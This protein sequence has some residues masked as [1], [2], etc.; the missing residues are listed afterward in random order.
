MP[1]TR[2]EIPV[3][4][5]NE[6]IRFLEARLAKEIGEPDRTIRPRRTVSDALSCEDLAQFLRVYTR[7]A[8]QEG[9]E[10][11][12][13]PPLEIYLNLVTSSQMMMTEAE[14]LAAVDAPAENSRRWLRVL[15]DK[16]VVV[17]SQN[18]AGNLYSVAPDHIADYQ[19]RI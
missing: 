2:Q 17:E 4:Y 11:C 9:L 6:H 18:A 15:V 8:G 16:G 5:R 1:R 19:F 10:V 3:T 12:K 13:S 14:L 7:I